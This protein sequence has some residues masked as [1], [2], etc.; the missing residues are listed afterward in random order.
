M[1]GDIRK[2]M[3]DTDDVKMVSVG[4]QDFTPDQIAGFVENSNR[5]TSFEKD[6]GQSLEDMNKS[7]GR[8]G[9]QIGELKGQLETYQGKLGDI[10]A[11]ELS[12]K[13]ADPQYQDTQAAR[14][15]LDSLLSD[16]GYAKKA[17]TIQELNTM[18]EGRQLLSEMDGLAT[19][20]NPYG[21]EGLPKFDTKEM[22]G[23]MDQYGV[24][25]PEMAY[26]IMYKDEI[27]TWKAGEMSKASPGGLHTDESSGAG[28]SKQPDPVKVTHKNIDELVRSSLNQQV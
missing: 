26:D 24:K 11:A 27:A 17:D 1:V 8:R 7:W 18:T 22:L 16:M 6:Q 13:Q 15:Q 21:E 9:T 12:K 10:E 23:F 19:K 3:S 2:H 28:Q 20:G 14:Q 5:L 4:D 25:N